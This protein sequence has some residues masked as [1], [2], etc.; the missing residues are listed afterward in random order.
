MTEAQ[1][2]ASTNPR[3]M[4]EFVRDKARAT[5]NPGK[6]ALFGVFRG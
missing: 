4:L 5:E 2:L 1:W 3:P 6:Q